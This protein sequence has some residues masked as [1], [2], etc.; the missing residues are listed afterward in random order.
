MDVVTALDADASPPTSPDEDTPPLLQMPNELVQQILGHLSPVDLARVSQT[1]RKLLDHAR[2]DRLWKPFVEGSTPSTALQ[3]NP[4][5][6]WRELYITHFPFWF[7][8]RR[9][10]WFSDSNHV[11]KLLLTRYNPVENAIEGY[12][13][14]AERGQNMFELWEWNPEVIIHTFDPRVRLDS[15]GPVIKLDRHA[16]SNAFG[17][18]SCSRLQQ[19]LMMNVHNSQASHGLYSMFML[20][21]PCPPEITTPGTK[22]WPPPSIPAQERTRNESI[23]RF[24]GTMHK[25]SKLSEVSETTWRLRKWMEFNQHPHAGGTTTRVG[26]EVTTFATLD[27]EVYTPT[28]QKPWRGIWCGDYA[29]HGCEFLVVMQPENPA[30]LPPGAQRAIANARRNSSVSSINS[31]AS[32]QSHQNTAAASTTSSGTVF[33]LDADDGSDDAAYPPVGP[34]VPPASYSNSAQQGH[35]QDS[36]TGAKDDFVDYDPSIYSGRIEAVKLTGDPNIPRGEYTFIAPDIGPD[37]FYR[38]AHEKIFQ[39][40]RVVRSVGHIAARG[41]RD[42]EFITSQ[43]IMISHD[44]LAQYW[45]PFGHVSFYQRVDVEALLA[46]RTNGN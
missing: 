34:Y 9:K 14:T 21:R 44:R 43:L 8:C 15:T 33:N 28:P 46:S 39:G 3:D 20:S 38:V 11:G 41:F 45:E 18:P 4:P 42:D 37:G 7:V 32:A 29:G 5:S 16:Y 26:E 36:V 40:A 13:L 30:P 1:C 6:S 17:D 35:R 2:E 12:A 24:R 22:V 10:L 23:N 25:P 31:F 27:A 19:E